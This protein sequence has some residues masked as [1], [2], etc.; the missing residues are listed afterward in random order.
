MFVMATRLANAKRESSS[1]FL[2]KRQKLRPRLR[3]GYTGYPEVVGFVEDVEGLR[4]DDAHP[5]SV[6]ECGHETA[7]GDS[8]GTT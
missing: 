1:D 5:V 8:S 7:D 3:H 6:P 4:R 2:T